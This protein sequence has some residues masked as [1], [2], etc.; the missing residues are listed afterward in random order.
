MFSHGSDSGYGSSVFLARYLRHGSR[1]YLSGTREDLYSELASLFTESA[2]PEDDDIEDDDNSQGD[3]MVGTV[4][5]EMAGTLVM[6]K[7]FT[8]TATA[9][10]VV[11]NEVLGHSYVFVSFSC[12]RCICL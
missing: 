10:Q 5:K 2:A 1:S 7:I 6:M 12:A 4:I 8:M 9:R 3:E 11:M